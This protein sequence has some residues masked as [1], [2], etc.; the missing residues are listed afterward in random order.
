MHEKCDCC[1]QPYFLE[2]MFYEGAQYVSYAIQ[3]AMFVSF[4]VAFRVL[5]D[6]FSVT[7]FVST[8]GITSILLIPFT[9]RISR[10]IWI[11]FFVRY[12]GPCKS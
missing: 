3:V 4:F 1:G 7:G 10:V 9:W 12:H 5:F 8:V 11:H 6:E 2:P